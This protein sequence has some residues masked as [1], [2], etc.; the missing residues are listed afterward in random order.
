ME[1]IALIVAIISIVLSVASW[2]RHNKVIKNLEEQIKIREDLD[3]IL[4]QLP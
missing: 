2:R 1:I 4:N 3:S